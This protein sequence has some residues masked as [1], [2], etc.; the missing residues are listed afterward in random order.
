MIIDLIDFE[1]KRVIV[2]ARFNT[3]TL[4]GKVL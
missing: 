3:D 1:I 4:S 2:A